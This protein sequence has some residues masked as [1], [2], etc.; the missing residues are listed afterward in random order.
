VTPKQGWVKEAASPLK[1]KL[2]EEVGIGSIEQTKKMVEDI[3]IEDS[4]E[5]EVRD[6]NKDDSKDLMSGIGQLVNSPGSMKLAKAFE[7]DEKKYAGMSKEEKIQDLAENMG[8][9]KGRRLD[10]FDVWSP[11]DD[12]D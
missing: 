3:S 10:N 12:L 6:R 2:I 4:D 8:S 11:D 5:D 7:E 1:P 9:T